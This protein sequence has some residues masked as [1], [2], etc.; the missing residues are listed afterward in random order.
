MKSLFNILLL[1]VISGNVLAGNI[2]VSNAR[3]TGKDT[4]T[5][6][7]YVTFDLTWDMSWRRPAP[8]NWD[9]A[10]VFV[11]FRRN[12]VLNV[13]EHMVFPFV[14]GTGTGDGHIPAPG[15]VIRSSNDNGAGGSFGVFI[16]GSSNFEPQTVNYTNV[17]LRWNYASQGV[18]DW[19]S[20]EICVFAIE[21]VYIP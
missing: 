2:Q 11:K 14:D 1:S 16:Y 19:D 5:N 15:S 12:P 20:V 4:A 21:M 18:S 7:V 10:W 17:R 8:R 6:T 13:W 9:A 3:F